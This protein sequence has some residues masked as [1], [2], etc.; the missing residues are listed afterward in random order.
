MVHLKIRGRGSAGIEAN[1][2]RV[3]GKV[4]GVGKSQTR[5]KLPGQ[6]ALR[7]R[8]HYEEGYSPPVF[9]ISISWKVRE[10]PHSF[11]GNS[12]RL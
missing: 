7:L 1:P 8:R 12:R 2:R 5:W 11:T 10:G 3:V 6:I 9:P 4:V